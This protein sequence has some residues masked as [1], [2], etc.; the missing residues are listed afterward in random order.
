MAGYFENIDL[1]NE[2]A[3]RTTKRYDFGEPAVATLHTLSENA[4]YLVSNPETARK[5][6]VL[7]VGRPGYHTLAEYESE[8]AWLRQI[9]DYTP[10]AVANPITARDESYIQHVEGTDGEVFTCIVTEFL[11][12]EAPDEEDTEHVVD[13][14]KLLG[15][16]TAYL[17]RQTYIWNKTK[18][19]SRWHWDF[20]NVIGATAK[21]GR[22]QDFSGI[23]SEETSQLARCA[24]IIKHRLERYGRSPENYG[25]IHA[26]LRQANILID[27]ES[28][29]KVIDFDDCGFGWHVQDLA[30]AISFIEHKEVVP[31]LINAWL[32]G[33]KKIMPFTDTDFMEIDTF[34][35]MRRLQLTAWMGSHIDSDP[36]KVMSVGWMD[37]TMGLARRYLRLFG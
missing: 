7:R 19:L 10:L 20:D 17:H 37:G 28:K 21:W 27:S 26:D 22:W 16:V 1:F 4:T 15:E 31:D 5:L 6:G 29:I 32:E 35:M 34:I 11:E 30:S 24:A 36:V 14:F 2:V 9:N 13:Q 8:I 18:D 23:T 25:L 3:A 12:G 33:Y